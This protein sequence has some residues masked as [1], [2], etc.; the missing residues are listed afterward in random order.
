MEKVFGFFYADY[1][2]LKTKSI[3]GYVSGVFYTNKLGFYKFILCENDTSENTGISLRNLIEVVGLLH[4]LYLEN[5]GNFKDSL[6]K[7]LLRKFGIFQIFTEPH[8]P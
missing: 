7:Q 4:S 5:H 2:K 1:I 3:R 6:F 8:S